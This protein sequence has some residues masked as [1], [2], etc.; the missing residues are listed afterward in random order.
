MGPTALPILGPYLDTAANES[1]DWI[2]YQGNRAWSTV[3]GGVAGIRQQGEMDLR[4]RRE[5]IDP[6]V[7][8]T[9]SHLARLGGDLRHRRLGEVGYD[10]HRILQAGRRAWSLW[11][12]EESNA[13]EQQSD[14]ERRTP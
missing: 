13:E 6:Q 3:S 8:T 2:G 12:Y 5:R 10:L 14:I 1:A 4:Q 9:R 11:W 7:Q